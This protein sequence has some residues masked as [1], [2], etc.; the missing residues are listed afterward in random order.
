M[1]QRPDGSR[2]ARMEPCRE[3]WLGVRVDI[4]RYGNI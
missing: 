2:K 1:L 3:D 4:F